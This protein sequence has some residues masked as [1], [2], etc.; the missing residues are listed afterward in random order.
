MVSYRLWMTNASRIIAGM[1]Y[2]GQWQERCEG[3]VVELSMANGILCVENILD[4]IRTG[5]KEP[6]DSVAAFFVNF[7]KRREVS[8]IGEATPAELDACRRLLPGFVDLFQILNIP[9]FPERKARSVLN[10][11]INNFSQNMHIKSDPGVADIIYRFF[12]RFMP[13]SVFPGK[14][15]VFLQKIF[16]KASAD[17]AGILNGQFIIE[18]FIARTGLPELFLNDDITLDRKD[19]LAE[20][21]KQIIG[22]EAACEAAAK[23]VTTFKAGMNDPNR[24]LGVL[25]FCGPTG[26]GKTALART[27]SNYFFGHGEESDRLIR[28]DMSEYNGPGAAERLLSGPE[29]EPSD[30]VKKIRRQPFSLVLLDEIE[31]A[32]MEVFDV[33]LNMFDEGRLVDRYGRITTFRSAII[34]MTSNLGASSQ[35][36]IGF[37]EQSASYESEIKSYFRPEFFNR[38]DQVVTFNPLNRSAL[39]KITEKEISEISAREGLAARNIQLS[40]TEQLVNHIAEKGFDHRFGARPLQRAVEKLLVTPLARYLAANPDTNK[41]TIKADLNKNG[42]V[43]LDVGK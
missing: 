1:K 7:L 43:V 33:F 12:A 4:L 11:M 26:V 23:L 20:F 2:L 41:T 6:I 40:W 3:M 21:N 30:L 31:K 34:I 16:E 10:K 8:I 9:A 32:S 14:S 39:L 27:L 38:I 17:Q 35:E 24:P 37:G 5:G 29:G 13:Y 22:Q 18:Q 15:I 19:V 28:L 25:L 42:E 36:S